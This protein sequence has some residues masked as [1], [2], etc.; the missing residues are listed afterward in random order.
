MGIFNVYCTFCSGPLSDHCEIGSD[1]PAEQ[2]ARREWV[3]RRV[4]WQTNNSCCYNSDDEAEDVKVERLRKIGITEEEEK[5]VKEEGRGAREY[6]AGDNPWEYYDPDLVSECDG[7]WLE[8]SCMALGI[9]DM[10]AEE[11]DQRFFFVPITYEDCGK[12]WTL[13]P[14]NDPEL[15]PGDEEAAC[16]CGYMDA[17][18]IYPF[19]QD[20][21]EV[22]SRAIQGNADTGT[23]DKRALFRAF[24]SQS[25]MLRL[26]LPYGDLDGPDQDWISVPGEEY[27]VISPLSF[28]PSPLSELIA[29]CEKPNG[30]DINRKFHGMSAKVQH[31]PFRSL[32]AEVTDMIVDYLP[33]DSVAQALVASWTLHSRAQS[34]GF[35]RR[36]IHQDMPWAWELLEML[37]TVD[38]G[39]LN[40]GT[41]Y[42]CLDRA[43]KPRYG[44]RERE[45]MALANR[46]RIWRPC[47]ILAGLYHKVRAGEELKDDEDEEDEEEEVSSPVHCDRSEIH[48]LFE[49]EADTAR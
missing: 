44:M 4:Y 39:C 33:R 30:D 49:G 42:Q 23:I 20:C 1:I 28:C 36:R 15:P 21:L 12:A 16:Y 11:G 6:E 43:T 27:A 3:D 47:E 37:N 26:D 46:R 18:Q 25:D 2:R 8:D 19:H 38:K 31:D 13:N 10:Y 34:Q 5:R 22:F 35:W 40:F 41:L 7:D 14:R 17:W 48:G 24:N 29:V 32:P 9:H 45:W